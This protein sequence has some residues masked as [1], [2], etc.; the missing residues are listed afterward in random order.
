[1]DNTILIEER[2]D[3]ITRFR[4][5]GDPLAICYPAKMK[6]RGQEITFTEL[7]LRHPTTK[8]RRMIHVFDMS[9]GSNDYR[10]EFDAEMLTWTLMAMLPGQM[11]EDELQ[12]ELLRI[13]HNRRTQQKRR[14]GLG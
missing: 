9:D 6:F 2:V 13:A 8:G 11:H 3:V 12:A 7:G 10:L 14:G 1:M 4:T 5:H